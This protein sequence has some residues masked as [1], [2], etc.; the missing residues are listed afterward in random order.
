MDTTSGNSLKLYIFCCSNSFNIDDFNGNFLNERGD[1]YK[2]ISL[3]CSGKANLP[4]FLKAFEKGA[5]GMILITCPGD[6]CHYLEGNRR[7]PRRAEE[8]SSLLSEIGLGEGRVA[9]YSMNGSSMKDIAAQVA[10]FS[11]KIR[12]IKSC[13]NLTDS[14]VASGN[15]ARTA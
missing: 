1:E 8:V 12:S 10:G 4:Y 11:D 5:D 9:V 13:I 15:A 7:A 2:I 6:E 14:S 3:P